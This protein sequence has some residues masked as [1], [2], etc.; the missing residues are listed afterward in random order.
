MRPSS[1]KSS[2]FKRAI[3]HICKWVGVFHLSS[4]LTGKKL[5]ILCYH[6]FAGSDEATF[7]PRL[8]INRDTFERRMKFLLENGF[9][10]IGLGE[11]LGLLQADALAKKS[12]VLTID[13]GFAGVFAYGVPILER[14]G[15]RSTVYVTTYNHLKN[16][17]V[18]RL[19]VQYLFWKTERESVD[20]CDLGLEEGVETK[21]MTERDREKASEMVTL[22]GETKL[23]EP[24]RQE[25]MKELA[26]QLGVE[27]D[28]IVSKRLFSIMT[29]EE[30]RAAMAR[31]MDVELH[32]HRHRLPMNAELVAKEIADNRAVLE[33]LAQRPLKHLCYPSGIWA[34]EQWPWLAA[35]GVES[36][37][38]CLPGLNDAKTPKLGLRRCLDGEN[39]SQIEFEAEMYGF[40]SLLR[41]GREYLRKSSRAG[42]PGLATAAPG[43]TTAD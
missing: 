39:L 36:A 29:A 7:R 43:N 31:G 35:L 42:E 40:A 20:L 9:R 5:R 3:L 26:K 13:D 19:V 27:L 1:Q 8:F 24:R 22:Y 18:F 32:T 14:F 17:P 33:P 37:T 2:L 30:L 41:A 34:K 38:T 6:G 10:V 11:A 23:D 21:L 28:A 4:A 25:L 15:F 16:T 12:V